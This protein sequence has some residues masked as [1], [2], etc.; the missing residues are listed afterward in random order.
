MPNNVRVDW[1]EHDVLIRTAQANREILL[2]IAHQTE[3]EAKVRARV[4]TGFM[5]NSAYV[6]GAGEN[7][8]VARSED[9]HETAPGPEHPQDDNEVILG[10]AANYTIYVEA[11]DPF[12]YPAAELV[13]QQAAGI[14]EPIGRRHFT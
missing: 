8:F 12:V 5:R 2:A 13:A 7:S 6:N 11:L 10:F 9:G 3:A 4:D 1:Y 14:I